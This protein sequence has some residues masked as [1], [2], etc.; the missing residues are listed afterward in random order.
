VVGEEEGIDNS[1]DEWLGERV[2]ATELV[3]GLLQRRSPC[4][5]W[6]RVV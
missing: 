6:F 3:E 4:T 2:A 5:S 1:G